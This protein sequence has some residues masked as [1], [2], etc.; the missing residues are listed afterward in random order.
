MRRFALLLWLCG[1]VVPERDMYLWLEEIESEKA[2]EWVRAH[3]EK[4]LELLTADPQYAEIEAQARAILLAKDRIPAPDLRGGWVVNFWQDADHPRGLWRRARPAEYEKPEPAWETMLDLDALARDEG[5]NWVWKGATT[6][7]PDHDRAMLFLS[8]GGKD[9]TVVREFDVPSRSFVAGGFALPE[10]KSRVSWLDRDTLFVGTDFGP[11]TLTKSGYPRQVRLWKRGTPHLDAPLVFEG[12]EEDVSVSAFTS[13][14]P[15]GSFTFVA[16]AKTFFEADMFLRAE[17]GQLRKLPFPDDASFEG[18][19]QGHLLATL[20]SEWRG[21]PAGAL[22]SVPVDRPDAAEAVYRPDERSSVTRVSTARQHLVLNVLSNVQG[23]VVKVRRTQGWELEPVALPDGGSAGVVSADPFD[24][25]VYVGYES[26]LVPYTLYAI[27]RDVR[28]V[29]RL[30]E[31]FDARRLAVDQFEAQSPDGTRVPYFV[32]R[33]D[34][35]AFDGSNPTLLY[36]YGGFEISMTPAYMAVA[37]KAWLE[38]GGVFALANIRGGGEF[39][40]KWHRAALKENR[41]RAYDDFIS[42]AEDLVRRR[43]TSPRRLGIMG[44]SNGGLLVGAAFTQRPYL[45]H[46]VVCQV[47][48][49][50]MLRYHKLLAGHSWMAEYGD[51]EDPEMAEVI[52]RYSP[53]QNVRPRTEYP[54][55]FFVTSTKDDRVHP[56]HARKMAAK[57]E[58]QGHDILYYE[59]IEGGHSAA[60]NLEQRVKRTALEYT[61]LFR[62]LVD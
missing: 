16:R 54:H 8:R 59:N 49:L 20:R 60:A 12:A 37:G 24:D 11:G 32:I 50:D 5:E 29:R 41:Q 53:Y 43:V 23:R 3:N 51:P 40:P 7:P 2:L 26:F 14:R 39:G 15:E 38:K 45:F 42:V 18:I 31:R 6:L 30:P 22:V 25:R 17:D 19:F 1:C 46:A 52:R 55:V 56:G 13:F 34:D 9:A 58:A 47:P 36:G 27:G 33:R 4:S 62:Q 35:L 48:L 28:P 21:F 44:G 10:A 61:Y 57:M